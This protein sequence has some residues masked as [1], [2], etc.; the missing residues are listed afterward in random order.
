MATFFPVASVQQWMHYDKFVHFTDTEPSPRVELYLEHAPR[1]FLERCRAFKDRVYSMHLSYSR[2]LGH[3]FDEMNLL[4]RFN[5][6]KLAVIHL[7]K[8]KDEAEMDR[9]L[10]EISRQARLK[11]VTTTVENLPDTTRKAL[12]GAFIGAELAGF[13]AK[14]LDRINNPYL[15][16]CFDTGHAVC[17]NLRDWDDPLIYK[18]IKHMHVHDSKRFHDLHRPILPSWGQNHFKHNLKKIIGNARFPL[19]LVC[20]NIEIE[21]QKKTFAYIETL[22][23]SNE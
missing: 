1:D 23:P 4:H 21:D 22:N 5:N 9:Q 11:N 19:G 10:R 14:K 16:L 13:I 6:A 12:T 20:E 17:N 3:A 15:G 18:W 8:P 7:D 2:G